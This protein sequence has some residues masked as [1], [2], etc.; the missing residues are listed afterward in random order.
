M[1]P[2][3]LLDEILRLSPEQRMQL[4]EEVWNSLTASP[5]AVGVPDWH[6]KELDARV[7]EP[8]TLSWP[9]VQARARRTTP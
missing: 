4:M 8:G 5:D 7:A 2:N 3:A 9:D 6:R 1:T